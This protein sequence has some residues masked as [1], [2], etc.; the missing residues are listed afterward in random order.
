VAA[1]ELDVEIPGINDSKLLSANRRLQL[2]NLIAQHSRQIR[3]GWAT[4]IEIDE[5]GLAEALR[6][7]YQRALK[8]ITAELV[9]T[10]NYPV[11]LPHISKIR[12]DQHFYSIAAASIV[13]K[14]LRD[15]LMR[16][17]HQFFPNYDWFNNV[18]YG[19]R[20]HLDSI[21]KSGINKLHRISFIKKSAY[22]GER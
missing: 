14:V 5:L 2:S 6:I 21:N 4:N 18:G 9:L 19:T 12:G 8:D 20:K 1:V 7:A 10:D 11:N 16:S 22:P 13:A 3:F 17:Y 15:S